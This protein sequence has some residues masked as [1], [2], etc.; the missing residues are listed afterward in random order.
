[1]ENGNVYQLRPPRGGRTVTAPEICDHIMLMALKLKA[2]DI[3]LGINQT[4]GDPVMLRFRIHGALKMVRSDYIVPV[5]KEVVSRFKVLAEMNITETIAPQDGQINVESPEGR[6]VLRVSTV[7]GQGWEILTIRVQRASDTLPAFDQILMTNQMRQRLSQLIR[8]K[9]GMIIL[10]GPAGSGKTTTIYSLISLLAC[11]ERKII[12]AEDPIETRL[13]FV[14]HTQVTARANFAQLCRSFMRQDADVIF[15]GEIRDPESAEVTIQLAQTGHLVLSTVHTRDSLGVISRLEALEVPSNLVATTLVASL[16][17]RLVPRLCANCRQESMP[18]Q[19]TMERLSRIGTPP[20][21]TK[22]YK[23]GPGCS[24]CIYGVS[25]R[26]P[27]FELFVPDTEISDMINRGSP[28]ASMYAAARRQGMVSLA[29]DALARVYWGYTDLNS[30]Y[31]FIFGPEYKDKQ[32]DK[33]AAPIAVEQEE[34]VTG[35]VILKTG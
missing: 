4:K 35:K 24:Q 7:P 10:N 1:M 30:V 27:I 16:A 13:P 11:P 9:S 17:Q 2:S 18:D 5:Y 19:T 3:H 29:E 12:T 8:Q 23:M 14:N 21:G 34:E 26:V 6:L 20:P 32:P 22:I 15:V 28:R 31:S 33:P 25:G